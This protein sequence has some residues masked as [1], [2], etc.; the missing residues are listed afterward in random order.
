MSMKF[1]VYHWILSLMV[2]FGLNSYAQK[3]N[4]TTLSPIDEA[5]VKNT[6][7]PF[8][9]NEL[10][11][12]NEVYGESLQKEVL[13]KPQRVKD[14]KHLLRNRIT[15]TKDY[16]PAKGYINLTEVPL[17]DVYVDNLKRDTSFNKETFNPLKYQMFFYSNQV[18]V[19]HL[20]NTEYYIIIGPQT[21]R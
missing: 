18:Y 3:R 5:Y 20:D 2:L 19:Y 13:D 16:N 12:L 21:G 10:K 9:P 11:M 1:K 17:F 14:I 7:A 6:T 8:T 15:Y 4:Q